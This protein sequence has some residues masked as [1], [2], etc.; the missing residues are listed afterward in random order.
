MDRE[1]TTPSEVAFSQQYQSVAG[2]LRFASATLAQPSQY[3]MAELGGNDPAS[4]RKEPSDAEHSNPSQRVSPGRC[5][6]DQ[7][8]NP[9]HERTRAVEPGCPSRLC[10]RAS[11]PYSWSGDLRHR[12]KGSGV[13]AA[14]GHRPFASRWRSGCLLHRWCGSYGLSKS[15]LP[16]TSTKSSPSN[17]A[18]VELRGCR[19]GLGELSGRYFKQTC[20]RC[21][22]FTEKARHYKNTSSFNGQN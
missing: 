2:R 7:A 15:E 16:R 22:S 18:V 19:D 10:L 13:G 17:P 1:T 21:E 6:P 11:R 12:S 8:R 5:Q 9:A 3:P 4:E 20:E 14:H